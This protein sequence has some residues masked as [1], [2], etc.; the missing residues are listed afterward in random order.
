MSIKIVSRKNGIWMI[1]IGVILML[2]NALL[3]IWT[4][5]DGIDILGFFILV[6]GLV[7]MVVG[8][9]K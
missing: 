1:I 9:K 6:I 7:I 8:W 4:N 2:L 3:D 5:I